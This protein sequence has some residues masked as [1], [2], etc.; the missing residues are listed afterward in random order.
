MPTSVRLDPEMQLL[1]KRLAR[2][3]G[4][5]RS[6]VLREALHRLAEASSEKE[7]NATVYSLVYDLLGAARQGAGPVDLTRR[8]KEAYRKALEAK[9]RK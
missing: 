1:L 8:H 3:S 5:S 4:R 9:H 6:E 2:R 7:K